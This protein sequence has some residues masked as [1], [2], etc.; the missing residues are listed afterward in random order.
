MLHACVALTRDGDRRLVSSFSVWGEYL[1]G[2]TTPS[3]PGPHYRGFIIELRHTAL[4][5]PL[6]TSDQLDAKSST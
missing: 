6:W 3:E 1:Y 4:A 5:R 2:V